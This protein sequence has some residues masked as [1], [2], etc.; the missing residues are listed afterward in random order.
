MIGG[1]E[2]ILIFM[3]KLFLYL[4]TTCHPF[5]FK[6]FLYLMQTPSVHQSTDTLNGL[7]SLFMQSICSPVGQSMDWL[8]ILDC[9]RLQSDWMVGGVEIYYSDSDSDFC[10]EWAILYSGLGLVNPMSYLHLGKYLLQ[11][12]LQALNPAQPRSPIL[13]GWDSL[14][15]WVTRLPGTLTNSRRV[16]TSYSA[17]FLCKLMIHIF[18]N[19][20]AFSQPQCSAEIQYR[21]LSLWNEES[22]G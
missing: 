15:G 14:E 4:T 18:V 22:P 1:R 5:H 9:T 6:L 10:L 21:L 3:Y 20:S 19:L 11:L 2:D 7:P 17:V 16:V 12:Q 8:G 13:R